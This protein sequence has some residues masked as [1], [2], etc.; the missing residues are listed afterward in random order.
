VNLPR[1]YLEE[2]SYDTSFSG[3]KTAVAHAVLSGTAGKEDIA[4][5]FQRAVACV[6][7]D[8]AMLAV[9]QTGARM[10][11][12]AGGVSANT[13]VR[14]LALERG[15]RSGIP[16]RIPP[17]VLCTDNAAMIA[18]AGYYA[19]LR[20]IRSGSDLNAYPNLALGSIPGL[21]EESD[22]EAS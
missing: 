7:I 21:P 14:R 12:L 9:R 2:G 8:K 16:V 22:V 5:S 17:P 10:L 20:G 18:C 4:A 19:F 13:E 11:T 3:L 1:A 15:R 6:L